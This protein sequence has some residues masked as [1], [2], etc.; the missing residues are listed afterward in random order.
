MIPTSYYYGVFTL[1]YSK[2]PLFRNALVI[3]LLKVIIIHTSAPRTKMREGKQ[4]QLQLLTSSQMF[5]YSLLY[6]VSLIVIHL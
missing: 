1:T 4:F 2:Y 3:D 6:L 5:M